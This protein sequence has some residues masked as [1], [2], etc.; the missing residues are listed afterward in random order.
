MIGS[1]W[2][3]V[4]SEGHSSLS[5]QFIKR[6]V[7]D[8]VRNLEQKEEGILDQNEYD[9]VIGSDYEKFNKYIIII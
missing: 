1:I 6:A 8:F 4:N 5:I 7:Q 3:G 2:E 9:A